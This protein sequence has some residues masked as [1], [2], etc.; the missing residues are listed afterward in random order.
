MNYLK[1]CF[2]VTFFVANSYSQKDVSLQKI[3]FHH[4]NAAYFNS[5]I[6]ILISQDFEDKTIFYVEVETSKHKNR[7]STTH[8]EV[9]KLSDVVSKISPNDIIKMERICLDSGNTEIEFS[10][11]LFGGS[12][13]YAVNCL[14]SN[15]NETAWK[16][17]FKSVIMILKLAKLEFSD[18]K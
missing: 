2:F 12:V 4:Q 3:R 16:D 9:L 10:K 7:Y 1:L 11:D 17:F 6:S 13:K 18:L 8:E 15:D 5:E 14:N